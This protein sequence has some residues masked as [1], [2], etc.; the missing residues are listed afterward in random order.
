MELAT[1]IFD[2]KIHEKLGGFRPNEIHLDVGCGRGQ[3]LVNAAKE[4]PKNLYIGVDVN[5][6][7]CEISKMKL[8]RSGVHNAIILER[9]GFEFISET[10]ASSSIHGVHVYFPTPYLNGLRTSP[11]VML[12]IKS[13][14]LVHDF[15]LECKRV[16]KPGGC[17][18]AVSDHSSYV[19]RAKRYAEEIGFKEVPWS[20]HLTRT[21][22]LDI[23]GTGCE[24]EMTSKGKTIHTLR[25]I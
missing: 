14:L 11:N 6:L 25:F 3:F 13:L 5:R 16:I 24:K 9:E 7:T 22:V 2:H 4:F 10:V 12:K 23:V 20:S 18:R 21:N 8:E 15:L 19:K 1:S 17:L